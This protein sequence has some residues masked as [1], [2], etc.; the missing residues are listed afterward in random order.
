MSDTVVPAGY[1]PARA[2]PANEVQPVIPPAEQVAQPLPPPTTGSYGQV[3]TDFTLTLDEVPDGAVERQPVEKLLAAALPWYTP[4]GSLMGWSKLKQAKLCLRSF[5]YSAVLGLVLRREPTYVLPETAPLFFDDDA[6]EPV[7]GGRKEYISPLDLG[8]LVHACVECW[9]RTGDDQAMWAPAEAVKH[10]HPATALEARRLV[11]F[12]L[13]RYAEDEA[14][15][16]DNRAVERESRYWFPPRKC[17]GKR[18]SLC[19]SARHDGIYRP[20]QPGEARLPPGTASKNNDI[21]V[22]ELKTSATLTYNRTRG[23]MQNAQ[24]MMGLLTY[25]RG[26]AVRKDGT[27]LAYPTAALFGSSEEVTVTWIGKTVRQDMQKDIDRMDYRIPSSRIDGFVADLEDWYYEEIGDRLFSTAYQQPETWRKDWQCAD[28]HF[29]GSICPFLSVCEVDGQCNLN[30]L[31][32]QIHPLN[33]DLL[34]KPKA[35]LKVDKGKAKATAI[36]EGK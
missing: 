24:V 22:H 35:L 28:I 10:H 30:V 6:P 3:M 33:R 15:T 2:V 8:T 11:N 1:V 26:H 9:Y 16:W 20:L 17:G 32:E 7:K 12:Y 14:T 4:G 21:R 29:S 18:R 5:Y 23:F 34:E 13:R 19:V 31:Y 27:V 25:N 36:V